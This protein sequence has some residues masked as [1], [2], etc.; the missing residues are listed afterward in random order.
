MTSSLDEMHA[1]NDGIHNA[2]DT[3]DN[4]NTKLTSENERGNHRILRLPSWFVIQLTITASLGGCLFGYD[5]GA[6]SGTLPELASTFDLNDRQKELVVSILYVGGAIGGCIGGSLCDRIGRRTTIILTD[7][8]FILGALLLYFASVYNHVVIGRFV[9]GIGVAV[10]G[11][12]DVS[13]LYECSPVE[14]RGSIVSVNEACISLGFLLAYVAGYVFTDGVEEWRVVFGVSGILAA[15]QCIGMLLLP[16][17]P[18]WLTEKGHVEAANRALELINGTKKCST[19]NGDSSG[20]EGVSSLGWGS[21]KRKT[22]FFTSGRRS[23][24]SHSQSDVGGESGIWRIN[25]ESHLRENDFGL[26]D[27]S[28][29][30]FENRNNTGVKRSLDLSGEEPSACLRSANDDMIIS[31]CS[32]CQ[33]LWTKLQTVKLTLSRYRHQVY[34]SLFLAVAQQ[35]C[36]Q[37]NIL[38]YAPLIFAESIKEDTGYDGN[39]NDDKDNAGETENKSMI[40]IG[41][42]KFTVTVFVIWR[43][44]YIGRRFLLIIGNSLIVAGLLALVISFGGSSNTADVDNSGDGGTSWSPLTGIKTFH[45][46]LPGVLLVVCGYSMSFG[47]LTWLLTS[48]MFPTEI[49]GRALGYS[50]IISYICGAISTETFLFSQS[51]LGP[52]AV[53][54][55]YSVF[56]FAC[57]LFAYLAIPDTGGKTVEEID[58]S[59][60]QMYWWKYRAISIS[61]NDEDVMHSPSPSSSSS[62]MVQSTPQISVRNVV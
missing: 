52:S 47:P 31:L 53:F 24:N 42:V 33:N 23:I 61:Q 59:L 22:S 6:I 14:W 49:R 30:G 55:V 51:I 35:F 1:A 21:S 10:S 44:E 39:V 17:S 60:N 46:A 15:I 48:E 2:D 18:A 54:G 4:K 41:L 45:L 56:T 27:T 8:V 19:T 26:E 37:T 43:I 3:Q 36:G 40:I 20:D 58:R 11:V 28:L 5:M 16:E 25:S 62:E 7:I 29:S 12:A 32:R 50:T 9:V 38:S 13:Y 34:I 57:V